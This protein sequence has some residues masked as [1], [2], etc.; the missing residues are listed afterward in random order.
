MI[1]YLWL[2]YVLF[3]HI[4][5]VAVNNIVEGTSILIQQVKENLK[6]KVIGCLKENSDELTPE[7]VKLIFDTFEDPF[8]NLKT[9]HL[10]SSFMAKN[11]NFVPPTQYVLGT[12]ISYKNKG[13][14]RLICEQDD[15]MVYIPI[16]DSLQQ[17]LSNPKIFDLVT[18]NQKVYKE[19]IFYDISDGQCFKNNPIFQEHEDAL[20]I[21]LYHDEVE[22]YNPLGSHVG[23]H[24]ID[25][26]YYTLANITQR[27][28]QS[29]Y[30]Q[31]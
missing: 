16:L 4:Q 14:K 2:F 1:F 7:A 19:G 6:E 23:K 15:T 27:Y 9:S 30:W 24:N 8:Q 3:I 21:I 22:V 10:Q 26:Y 13:S 25:L 5:K 17:F 31:L 28:V 11:M 18:S 29:G 20:Q 12:K